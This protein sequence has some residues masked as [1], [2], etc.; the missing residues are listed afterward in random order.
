MRL[1]T[2]DAESSSARW[3]RQLRSSA[4]CESAYGRALCGRDCRYGDCQEGIPSLLVAVYIII[5]H[6]PVVI[7]AIMLEGIAVSYRTMICGT[8]WPDGHLLARSHD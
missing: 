5:R 2:E 8:A 4:F 7:T 1:K 6:Q 3:S